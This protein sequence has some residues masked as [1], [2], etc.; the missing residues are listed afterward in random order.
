MSSAQPGRKG[1]G[2][3]P[4]PRHLRTARVLC[5]A[6][7]SLALA[8]G[9]LSWAAP[10]LAADSSM[11]GLDAPSVSATEAIAVDG[12]GDVLFSRDS[13]T[14]MGMA[15]ITKVMTATV[16]LESG[17]SLD[18]VY[19]FTPAALDISPESSIIGYEVGDTATLR[20][21]LFG[22]LVH[23]GNDAAMGVA[24]C[25]AGSVP[26]FVEMMNAKAAALGMRDT[27]FMNP[28][29]LDEEGHYST[30]EDLVVLARHAMT[31]PLLRSIVGSP[32]TTVTLRGELSTFASTDVLL[33][34]YPGMRGI[35]TGYTYGAGRAFLGMATRG[36][37]TV[38]VVVLGTESGDA[39]WADV[40]T[41]LDWSF[42][43]MAE[44][45]LARSASPLLGRLRFADLFGWT[46]A[47]APLEDA[48]ARLS[49]AGA[50]SVSGASSTAGASSLVPAGRTVGQVTWTDGDGA[51]VASRPL[52]G[53][54]LLEPAH[55]FGP[56][57]SD[58]FYQ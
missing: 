30:A 40:Q 1:T 26:A 31:L 43:H 51:T 29:G 37:Q 53:S 17:V 19:T 6:A 8:A 15:S 38:Y 45:P 56:F 25:V 4:S 3:M 7:C 52:V 41:L 5:A 49:A 42:G 11:F 34:V 22:L 27:G 23:S 57:V 14:R 20:E 33:N 48:S 10:A 2:H 44:T 9:P 18:T 13:S 55:A 35:K 21:L 47:V 24:E 50:S 12:D 28:H 16:A 46:V 58:V 39:R 32:W 54:S 36:G